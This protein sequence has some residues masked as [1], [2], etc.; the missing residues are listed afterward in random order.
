MK[1]A[2]LNRVCQSALIFGLLVFETSTAQ[3]QEGVELAFD[4]DPLPEWGIE[5]SL[6][7]RYNDFRIYGDG[8]NNPFSSV[9][10][11]Y[12]GNFDL[13]IN[14]VFSQFN[15]LEGQFFG[16]LNFSDFR[17]NQ[18]N[19][20]PERGGLTWTY[21]E[22]AL[23][24][25][26]TAGDFFAYLT[27]LTLNTSLKGLSVD[28]QSPSQFFGAEHS[29]LTFAGTQMQ[30]YRD[31]DQFDDR[32]HVGASWLMDWKN[33]ALSF[34]W[35]TG[36][37]GADVSSTGEPVIRS[38]TSVAIS[39][40]I[41]P[42]DNHRITINGEL[43]TSLGDVIQIGDKKSGTGGYGEIRG[44]YGSVNY[45]GRFER[46]D[47]GYTPIGASIESDRQLASLEFGKSFANGFA[48]QLRAEDIQENFSANLAG[49]PLATTR[50]LGTNIRGGT[51]NV[52]FLK[53]ING[54]LDVFIQENDLSDNSRQS[55]NFVANLNTNFVLTDKISANIGLLYDESNDQIGTGDSKRRQARFGVR[56]SIDLLGTKGSVNLGLILRDFNALNSDDFDYGSSLDLS[57]KKGRHSLRI[58][59][60]YLAQRPS[61]VT[62]EVDTTRISAR[63]TYRRG[64][65]I[66]GLHA[67]LDRRAPF[68]QQ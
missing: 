57:L 39:T 65:H 9:G 22:D 38:A 2:Y 25:R 18:R 64:P 43:A 60:N 1:L 48:V 8:A 14:R 10:S 20:V 24:F 34:N 55:Q 13:G 17:A 5:G 3:A 33:T 4:K 35:N 31:L 62:S 47:D 45:R 41:N 63:Y 53:A 66:L 56:R 26:A 49:G 61:L 28:M 16:A 29:L 21:G 19:F 67:S 12:F 40:N 51:K 6:S 52:G 54:S 7:L 59:G 50:T 27:P 37:I 44:N 30:S 23:S 58:N 11:Q 15:S 42:S 46:F 36:R 32:Q 68:G